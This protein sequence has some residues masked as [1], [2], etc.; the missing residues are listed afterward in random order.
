MKNKTKNKNKRPITSIFAFISFIYVVPTG[1]LTHFGEHGLEQ[2]QHMIGATHWTSSLIFLVSAIIHII[3]NWK[4][5]RRY[6]FTEI[7]ILSGFKKEFVIVFIAV[8]SLIILVAS[9]FLLNPTNA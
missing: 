8:T 7:E 5:M 1:I 2:F 9:P 6:M 4:A 3:L